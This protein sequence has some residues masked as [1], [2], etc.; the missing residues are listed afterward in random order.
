MKTK[1]NFAF[2]S[3]HKKHEKY[4]QHKSPFYV[5]F[6][7]QVLA[8]FN[9]VAQLQRKPPSCVVFGHG[10]EESDALRK[11]STLAILFAATAFLA[12]AR[13]PPQ[14][15]LPEPRPDAGQA[16]SPTSPSSE[17]PDPPA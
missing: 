4:C 5:E 9:D 10:Y 2:F 17:K 16:T 8:I 15:P 13:L 3:P 12:G 7:P 6:T 11:L 14:G 1:K